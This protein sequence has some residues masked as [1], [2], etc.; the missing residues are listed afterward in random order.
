MHSICPV[1][2]H[3]VS[4]QQIAYQAKRGL[5]KLLPT[6]R[7]DT[8]SFLIGI[9]TF[10]SITMATP[11]EHFDDLILTKKDSIVEGIE[12]GLAIKGKGTFKFN[13]EDDHGKVHCIEI[14]NCAY[15][16]GL[17]YCLLSPQHWAQ[18]AKD[19]FPLLRGTR[20]ENDDEAIILLWGQGKYCRT[21][22]H[23]PNTNTPVFRTAPAFYTYRAFVANVE[24]MEAQYHCNKKGHPAP[25]S[26][27]SVN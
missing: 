10:A 21:V 14:P 5:S 11:S 26:M 12:G 25:W 8:D 13:I 23:S 6:M 9:D 15:V 22:H 18:E 19:K 17:K 24:A 16:P 20:M 2:L 7:L 4:L 1:F 27:P 3:P